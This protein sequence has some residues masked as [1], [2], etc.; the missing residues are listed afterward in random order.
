M[1]KFVSKSA[2][3]NWPVAYTGLVENADCGTCKILKFQNKS[4]IFPTDSIFAS[5]LT[6]YVV[7][8]KNVFG[9]SGKIIW[10]IENAERQKNALGTAQ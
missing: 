8:H 9:I 5:L 10:S 7:H 1:I 3:Q 2:K 6:Q 4:K